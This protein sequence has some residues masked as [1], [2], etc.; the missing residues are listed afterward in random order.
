MPNWYPSWTQCSL[1][2]NFRGAPY[3]G[4]L[5]T[6]IVGVLMGVLVGLVTATTGSGVLA[7]LISLS[8]AVALALAVACMAAIQF[9]TWWL[10]VRLICLG[11]DRSAIG[12]IYHLEPPAPTDNPV[13]SLTNISDLDTDYSFNLLLWQFA[14]KHQLPASFISNQWS[15][16]AF[17]QL[18]AD[19]PTLP[20][21]VPGVPFAEVSD[22]VNQIVPQ[23][24]MASLGLGFG[25]QNAESPDNAVLSGGSSQHFLMHC[26]IEGPGMHDLLVLLWVLFA[27]FVAATFV[28]AIPVVGP[29]LSA[30][31]TLLALLGFLIGAPAITHDGA[32]PPSDGGWG[33]NFN[34]YD[35]TK[36]PKDP[37]DIAYV[38]GRWVYDSL[39]TGAES[40]ELHPVHYMIKMCPSATQGDLGNGIWP[41]GLGEVQLKY[42]A[43]FA[44]INSPTT[45][46]IQAQAQNQ[47]TVHPLLDGCLAGA[48][49]PEPPPPGPVIV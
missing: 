36:N 42:D 38:F 22:Q 41:S 15:A 30:L 43:Q 6:G 37:V 11:G 47:W 19:W 5:T 12:A 44:V 39:H 45:P 32:S 16:S 26:E 4:V 29:I 10:N 18:G 33:G 25:G 48:G 24:S 23:Q 27:I 31:L 14:P 35:P 49:Y 20:P 21:L 9:C 17:S 8:P 3:T 1:P 7:F 46:Q 28:Y 34:S 13:T 2:A 40:N